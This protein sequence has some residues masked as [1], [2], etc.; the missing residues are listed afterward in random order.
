MPF[1]SSYGFNLRPGDILYCGKNKYTWGVGHVGIVG[2]DGL[3]RHVI[4]YGKQ[5]NSI[6]VFF[7]NFA[8]VSVYRYKDEKVSFEAAEMSEELFKEIERYSLHPSLKNVRFT[9]CTKY[10]WQSF[11]YSQSKDVI[12]DHS[13]KDWLIILPWLFRYKTK[14]AFKKVLTFRLN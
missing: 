7:T 8:R 11:Y 5:L 1:P 3:V 13:E 9:H 12:W 14:G 6:D 4:P 10:I 2:T